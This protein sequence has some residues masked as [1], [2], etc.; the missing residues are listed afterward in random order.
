M[1][2]RVLLVIFASLV[3]SLTIT[4]SLNYWDDFNVKL[5]YNPDF[6]SDE[7]KIFLI[8]SSQTRRLNA[9]FIEKYI[10]TTQNDFKVYNLSKPADKPKQ[11]INELQDIIDAKPTSCRRRRSSRRPRSPGPPPAPASRPRVP[12]PPRRRARARGAGRGTRL[13]PP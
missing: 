12:R 7:K 3:L 9:T 13:P 1:V 8:G 6:D 10:E 2:V 5:F 4:Y 11:R